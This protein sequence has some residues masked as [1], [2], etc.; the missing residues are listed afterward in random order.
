MSTEYMADSF[1][2]ANHPRAEDIRSAVESS[3]TI[4]GED[5]WDGGSLIEY[6][7]SDVA[8]L[9]ERLGELG[10]QLSDTDMDSLYVFA[11]DYAGQL[12]AKR[13][14]E[15]DAKLFEE[16]A[17]EGLYYGILPAAQSWVDE[18]GA[19]LAPDEAKAVANLL[20]RMRYGLE[21]NNPG[22]NDD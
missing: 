19:T 5:A 3:M 17:R 12:D 21:S 20:A 15:S 13:D 9:Q 8:R 16:E 10:I 22:G 2:F 7:R 14:A 4:D 18:K 11:G 1:P 6:V